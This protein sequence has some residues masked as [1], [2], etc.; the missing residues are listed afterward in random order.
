MDRRMS[1]QENKTARVARQVASV[2]A[3]RL[4][5]VMPLPQAHK[6]ACC[7]SVAA[8]LPELGDI[9]E[10]HRHLALDISW[11][12]GSCP[13]RAARWHLK[14]WEI[15]PSLKQRI[16][17]RI[18]QKC[19]CLVRSRGVTCCHSLETGQPSGVGRGRHLS[20]YTQTIF[21]SKM[22]PQNRKQA[23]SSGT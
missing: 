14:S 17:S 10:T 22:I 9:T 20:F 5:W 13:S 19:Q 2:L 3:Q 8:C 1:K 18:L 15:H 4:C 6:W 7:Y 23:R 21:F 12:M 11:E 16:D